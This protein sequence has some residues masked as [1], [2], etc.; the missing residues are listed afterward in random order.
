VFQAKEAAIKE[1]LY[2]P[3]VCHIPNQGL[4][5][6]FVKLPIILHYQMLGEANEWAYCN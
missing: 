1:I 4:V 3:R 5:E 2:I 6:H